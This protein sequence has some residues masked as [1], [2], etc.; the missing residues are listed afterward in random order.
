VAAAG[1]DTATLRTDQ[2]NDPEIGPILREIE[3]GQ[4]PE[5]KEIADRCL[6]YKSYWA[7]WKSLAVR[8]GI[9]QR[10]W[11]SANGRVTIAAVC[12]RRLKKE[13]ALAV[14][15]KCSSQQFLRSS[16]YQ[17]KLLVHVI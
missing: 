2:L 14:L 12:D 8:N 13:F 15:N 6:T 11:E 5:W 1:W 9:L 17:K 7:Q 10:N 4:R 3:T 16:S